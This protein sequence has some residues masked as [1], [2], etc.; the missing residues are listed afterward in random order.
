MLMTFDGGV[1]AATFCGTDTPFPTEA[2]SG[3]PRE[4]RIRRCCVSFVWEGE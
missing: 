1:R 4:V 3:T 2:L